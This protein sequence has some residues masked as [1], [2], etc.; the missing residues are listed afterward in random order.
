[1]TNHENTR[2]V[3]SV[4]CFIYSSFGLLGHKKH[5]LDMLTH[6]TVFGHSHQVPPWVKLPAFYLL[7]AISKN[8]F[9]PYAR[10]FAPFVIRLF[11]ETYQQVD[12]P[13]RSKM[14]EMLITWRTGAPGDKEL[15]GTITQRSIEQGI[16]G[17]DLTSQVDVSTASSSWLIHRSFH[18]QPGGHNQVSRAQ[19]LSEL[20]FTL[21]QKERSVQANPWDQAIQRHIQ[22]LQQVGYMLH[23]ETRT[24][25]FTILVTDAC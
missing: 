24:T 23:H 17:G 1:M 5:C 9:D 4:V 19:V 25:H 20:E 11:L 8:V 12:Q 21:G 7:D 14:E 22:V 13:T 6:L 16:W 18:C 3:E 2:H 10:H 15:F